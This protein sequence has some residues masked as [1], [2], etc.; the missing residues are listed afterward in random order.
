ML[1]AQKTDELCFHIT[2]VVDMSRFI[3]I[4]VFFS[5]FSCT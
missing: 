2:V 3:G 5:T 1:A 4:F